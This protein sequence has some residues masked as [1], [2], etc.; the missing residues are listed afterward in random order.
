MSEE[1]ATVA[2]IDL[3]LVDDCLER[4]FAVSSARAQRFGAPNE[5]LWRVL[6]RASMGGRT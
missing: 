4:F 1:A 5:E 2:Q 6:R 3:A